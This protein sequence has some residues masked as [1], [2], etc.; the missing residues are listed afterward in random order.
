MGSPAALQDADAVFRDALLHLPEAM[1]EAYA[2]LVALG[3]LPIKGTEVTRGVLLR[4]QAFYEAQWSIKEFLGKRYIGAAADF[5]VETVAF[6]L[7][8]LVAT[9]QLNIEVSSERQV[10][11]ARG[12]MRPD[13]SLWS[14]EK[15]LACIECKTQLGWN[16]HGWESRFNEREQR[17]LAD[18][19]GSKSFLVVLTAR[20]WAGFGDNPLVGERYFVLSDVWPTNIDFGQLGEA[21]I[22]PIEQLFERVVE[23]AAPYASDQRPVRGAQYPHGF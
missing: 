22:T 10:R 13:I 21:V 20:N 3:P 23:I 8:A 6:Y 2:R 18:H 1:E 17:L 16:R 7:K 4:M 12:A 14:E 11:R 19:A 5:F 9:H 15:C